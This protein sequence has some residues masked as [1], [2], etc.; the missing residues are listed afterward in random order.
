MPIHPKDHD[1]ANPRLQCP[2]CGQWM[3]LYG[4]DRDGRI[5]QRFYGGCTYTHGDHL[6][7]PGPDPSVCE[8]CCKVACEAIA[9]GRAAG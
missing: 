7:G 8:Q 1:A 4:R 5:I 3:R 6:A 9:I 2:V